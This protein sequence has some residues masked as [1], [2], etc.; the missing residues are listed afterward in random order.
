MTDKKRVAEFIQRFSELIGVP[1]P[2]LDNDGF[3]QVFE[4]SGAD[5]NLVRLGGVAGSRGVCSGVGGYDRPR[6]KQEDS[7]DRELH[8]CDRLNRRCISAL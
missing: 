7:H 5:D 3:T 1:I 2:P 8:R 6:R 4:A